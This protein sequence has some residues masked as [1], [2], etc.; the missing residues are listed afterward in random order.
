[1]FSPL[2]KAEVAV[3]KLLKQRPLD[4]ALG[5]FVLEEV[6]QSVLQT[7][8]VLRSGLF[9]GELMQAGILLVKG[10]KKPNKYILGS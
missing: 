5:R 4:D 1:M 2:I 9:L 7:S 6:D 10:L 3:S 8:V